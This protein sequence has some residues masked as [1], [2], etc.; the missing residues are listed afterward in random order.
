MALAVPEANAREHATR[1]RWRSP[2]TRILLGDFP[3]S[4]GKNYERPLSV[5][6]GR[7]RE[8]SVQPGLLRVESDLPA[9]I[10]VIADQFSSGNTNRFTQARV[11]Q[12]EDPQTCRAY[13][14]DP[15]NHFER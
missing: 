10:E 2:N 14:A 3:H 4:A 7:R 11:S 6:R 15:A 5:K 9:S 8:Y 13:P 1:P 12:I